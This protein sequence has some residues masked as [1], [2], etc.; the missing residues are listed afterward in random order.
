MGQEH[1]PRLGQKTMQGIARWSPLGATS[2]AFASFLLKQDWAT[3]LWL[4]PGMVVSGIWAAYSK[5]FI[6]RLN[7]IYAERA[8]KDAD[9]LVAWMDSL[10]EALMWQFS[11]F[12]Q[13]TLS[14]KPS[15]VSIMKRRAI[16]LTEL[17]FQC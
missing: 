11:G 13:I 12:D 4:F 15:F 17:R 10:N 6:E 14:N 1:P 2:W 5:N 16:I 3:A 7:E 9:A 8:K